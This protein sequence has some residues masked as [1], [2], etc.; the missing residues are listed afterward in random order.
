MNQALAKWATVK[1]AEVFNR[2]M[3]TTTRV[4]VSGHG[5]NLA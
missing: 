2:M 4:G 5:F 3:T 1:N